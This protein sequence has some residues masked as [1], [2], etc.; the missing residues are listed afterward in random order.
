M[1]KTLLQWSKNV[2]TN[3]LIED[4][5]FKKWLNTIYMNINLFY[6]FHWN[7]LNIAQDKISNM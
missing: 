7:K 4:L 5:I 1:G 2:Y 3:F 6:E